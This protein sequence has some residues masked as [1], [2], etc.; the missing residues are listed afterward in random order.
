MRA[1]LFLTITLC[2]SIIIAAQ[3]LIPTKTVAKAYWAD[4]NGNTTVQSQWESEQFY[5]TFAWDTESGCYS[6]A[7]YERGGQ[8][9]INQTVICQG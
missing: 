5:L 3:P 2:L 8:G 7:S 1:K 4:V 6:E 9:L